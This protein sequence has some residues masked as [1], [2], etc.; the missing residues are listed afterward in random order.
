M[1][2]IKDLP[3]NTNYKGEKSEN[4]LTTIGKYML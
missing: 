3:F 4:Q 2:G 1:R